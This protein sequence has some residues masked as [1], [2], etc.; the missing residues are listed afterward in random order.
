MSP[1]LTPLVIQPSAPFPFF[2]NLSL[3][4]AFTLHDERTGESVDARVKVPSELAQ[5]VPVCADVPPGQQLFVRLHEV[6][7]E[8]AHKLYP[9]MRLTAPTLFRLTR[10]AE[11]ELD[12]HADHDVRELVREQ[13]R[14]RRYEPVVRLEFAARSAGPIGQ[15]L[16]ERFALTPEDIYDLPGELDYTSLFQIAALDV[17]PT[18][19]TR[20]GRPSRPLVSAATR[21]SSTSSAPAIS[22]SITPTTASTTASSGSSAPPPTTRT[23]SPSR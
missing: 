2:S 20:R 17:C 19:A 4:L 22:W 10:D 1:A 16:Q 13:I 15:T 6:I 9:G 3:S 23:P 18:C 8:N 21:T 7:R 14:Q 12:E 11:V 5:W